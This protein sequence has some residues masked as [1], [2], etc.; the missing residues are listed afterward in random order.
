[1]GDQYKSTQKLYAEYDSQQEL[2]CGVLFKHIS[3]KT[4]V[5]G[6]FLQE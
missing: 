4:S 2:T 3:I 5:M 6:R 1:M